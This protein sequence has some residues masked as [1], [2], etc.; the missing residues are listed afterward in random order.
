LAKAPVT[1]LGNPL[2]E[3]ETL[4]ENPPMSVNVIV[5]VAVL[6]CTIETVG[7]EAD[8]VKLGVLTV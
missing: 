6:P 1:P 7:G 4:L 5:L 2:T 8:S 3:R